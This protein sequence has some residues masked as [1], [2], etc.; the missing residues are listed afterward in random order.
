MS[1]ILRVGLSGGEAQLGQVAASDVAHLLLGVERAVA[2]ATGGVLG[3][4]VKATGRWGK[5][6]E[7]A[8]RFRLVAVEEGSV[9]GVL[10]LPEVEQELDAL[11]LDASTLGQ[12]ALAAA[13]RTAAGETED[14]D[15]AGAFVT[16][17]DRVGVGSRY[18]SVTF[19]AG[20]PGAPRKVVVD[21]LARERLRRV[22]EREPPEPRA[23][24]LVGVLVEA[25]FE[26]YTARLRAASG[27]PV[28]VTFDQEQSDE[29]HEALRRPAELVGEIRYD[30]ETARAEAVELRA[31]TRAEQLALTLD[32]GEFWRDVTIEELRRDRG[33]EP[34]GDIDRLRDPELTQDE[35]D[36]FLAALES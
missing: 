4:Q 21:V 34:V 20:V 32:S 27:Q 2:R 25:D 14:A 18:E 15:V 5:T 31:I 6:V 29:I 24:T 30:P 3:R 28:A 33:V 11:D 13:L 8:V 23:D 26:K 9:V 10:E 7:S 22:A 16:L 12:M 35:V 17:A 19:D 1:K 36:A